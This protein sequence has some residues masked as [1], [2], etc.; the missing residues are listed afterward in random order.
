M[1]TDK[2][3]S[4]DVEFWNGYSYKILTSKIIP[5]FLENKPS[6]TLG[7]EFGHRYNVLTKADSI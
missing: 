5:N 2:D 7:N 4:N 3:N 1:K 6:D